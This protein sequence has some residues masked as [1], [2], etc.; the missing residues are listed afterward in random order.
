[1]NKLIYVGFTILDISKIC[2]YEFHYEYMKDR[3]GDKCQLQYCD[4]DSLIYLIKEINIYEM[5]KQGSH[6]FDASDYPENN[7]FGIKQLNNKIPG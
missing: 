6:R 5:M 4:T 2:F 3:F 7:I 1:M